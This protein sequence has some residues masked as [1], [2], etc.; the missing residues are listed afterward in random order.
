MG[1]LKRLLGGADNA[2]PAGE[3]V[4]TQGIYFYVQCDRCGAGVR[5]RAD[6]QHDLLNEENGFSWHKTIVDSRCFRPMPTVVTLNAAYEVVAHE[7]TGGHYITKDEYEALLAQEAE[8]KRA[9]IEPP[10]SE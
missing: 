4:D 5:L 2:K 8:A 9:A 10:P 7:I 6:K 3:Y 1:F